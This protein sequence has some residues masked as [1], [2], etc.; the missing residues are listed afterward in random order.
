[1]STKPAPRVKIYMK[2][3]DCLINGKNNLIN[4]KKRTIALQNGVNG[5]N[6]QIVKVLTKHANKTTY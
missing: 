1:M 5:K 4:F 3:L 6:A 2:K